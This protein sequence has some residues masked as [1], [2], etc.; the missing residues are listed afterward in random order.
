VDA[1]DEA[2]LQR[3]AQEHLSAPGARASLTS[4]DMAERAGAEGYQFDIVTEV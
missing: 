4:A 2:S 1:L 3:A